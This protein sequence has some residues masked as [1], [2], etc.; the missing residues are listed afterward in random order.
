M[1]FKAGMIITVAGENDPKEKWLIINYQDGRYHLYS[2]YYK[3][4]KTQFHLLERTIQK[5]Y[6]IK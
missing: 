4:D 3:S 2:D 6:E 1:K 5:Y